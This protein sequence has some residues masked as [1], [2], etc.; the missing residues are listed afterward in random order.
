MNARF[1]RSL[2]VTARR[3]VT[4]ALPVVTVTLAQAAPILWTGSSITFSQ[5]VAS[6]ASKDVIIPGAVELT[7]NNSKW[8]FNAGAGQTAAVVG[9]PSDTRWAFAMRSGTNIIITSLADVTNLTYNTFDSYRNGNLDQV[10]LGNKQMVVHL[11]NE[12]IYIPVK[13]TAWPHGGGRFAY[14]RSTAPA[15]APTVSITDPPSGSVFAEPVSLQVQ[16]TA[17]MSGGSVTN[18][19]FFGNAVPL[20]SDQTEP[21]SIT[22]DSL[23]VG[24]YSFTAVATAEG[25]STTSAPVNITVVAPVDITLTSPQI[26]NNVFS[27]EYTANPGL[28]YVVEN[29]SNLVDWLPAATNVAAANPVHYSDPAVP[30]DSRYF[31]VGRLPNP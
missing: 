5:T 18:V 3:F 11:L 30:N 19:A 27:F 23:T 28:R 4:L 7:R 25:I 6:S 1:K 26:T 14:I 29:S 13:F 22:T 10:L 15:A 21:F 12:D 9:S 20:G 24:L 31:R 8:L 2:L 17:A 16:A